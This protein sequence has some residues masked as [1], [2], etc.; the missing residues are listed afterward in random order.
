[1][2]I[3]TQLSQKG[4]GKE[5]SDLFP[6]VI[7]FISFTSPLSIKLCVRCARAGQF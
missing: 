3:Q 2:G 5:Y 4:K 1:M 7:R 6:L